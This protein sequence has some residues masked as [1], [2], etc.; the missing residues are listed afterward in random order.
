M[1]GSCEIGGFLFTPSLSTLN[2]E[3]YVCTLSK[4]MVRE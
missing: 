4:A 3:F 2:Q 1:S